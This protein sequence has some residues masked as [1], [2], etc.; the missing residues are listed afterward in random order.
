MTTLQDKPAAEFDQDRYD[1]GRYDGV[2]ETPDKTGDTK[3]MWDRRNPDEVAMARAA[4]DTAMTRRA[5][6][7]KAEGKEGTRG[8][9][10]RE[11]DETA[12]RL[13][14]VPQIVGG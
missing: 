2:I 4:F 6:V 7:Y 5:M 13:V 8:E 14:V 11:F 3:I 1:A 12:E 10:I 9:Q